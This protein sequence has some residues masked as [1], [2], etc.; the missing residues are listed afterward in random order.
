MDKATTL[1]APLGR[2]LLSVIF[3]LAGSSKVTGAE[4][5]IQ[6]IA[7]HGLPFPQL[8]YVVALIVEIGGGLLILIGYQARAAAAVLALFCVVTAIFFHFD[9]ADQGQMT[10]FLKNLAIA[11]GF[12]QIVAHGAGA[13]SLDNRKG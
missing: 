12:L 3:L 6:Y 9:P 4:G 2:L 5:T 11:G 10:N 7:A 13:W 8:A 1:S